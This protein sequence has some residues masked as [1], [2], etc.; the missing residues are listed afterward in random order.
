[1]RDFIDAFFDPAIL[2]KVWPLLLRGLWDTVLLSLIAVPLGLAAG[3]GLALLMQQRAA[4][5][6]PVT[7]LVDLLRSLPP[8]VLLVLLYAGL[9]F[10]GLDL[11]SWGSVA[12]CFLL[13]S[14][15]YYCEVFRSGLLGVPDGQ[16]DAGRALGL[17]PWQVQALVVLPQAVRLI[18]PDLLSNTLEVVKLTSI[19]SVAALPELLYVARQAQSVTY[20]ATPIVGA[21]IAY[22]LLL[23]PGVR[24]LSRLEARRLARTR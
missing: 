13:N 5:R 24:L 20:S 23:W 1:M 19:A 21:A 11:G 9:P 12:L 2:A 14:G 18:L 10:A 8:L 7:V 22:F 15:A 3:L 6:R 16:A 4:I 17:R